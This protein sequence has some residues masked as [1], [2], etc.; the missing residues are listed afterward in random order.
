MENITGYWC[1][2]IWYGPGFII[3]SI[4]ILMT[5][6]IVQNLIYGLNIRIQ[7]KAILNQQIKKKKCFAFKF[8][9]FFLS[10]FKQISVN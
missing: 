5:L 6:S 9:A 10:I 8:F 2:N 4:L 3:S 7:N 1:W